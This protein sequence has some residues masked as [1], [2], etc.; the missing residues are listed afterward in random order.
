MVNLNSSRKFQRRRE[1]FICRNCG[2]SVQGNGYTNHCPVCLWSRHVDINPGDR[3]AACRGMM[4]P[5]GAEIK[6]Q[7]YIIIHRCR[8]CG[9][10]KKNKVAE[11]DNP[12]V[13]S[14]LF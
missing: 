4:E 10:E 14:S 5:I 1:N 3:R 12:A 11:N 8:Q 6:A 2:A 9:H 7:K 13:L